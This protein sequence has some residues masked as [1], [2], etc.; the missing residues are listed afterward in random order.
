MTVAA[1]SVSHD[2]AQNDLPDSRNAQYGMA[3]IVSRVMDQ[4]N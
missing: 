1:S 2:L 3:H 4:F